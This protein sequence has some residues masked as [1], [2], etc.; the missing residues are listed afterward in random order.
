MKTINKAKRERPIKWKKITEQPQDLNEE[1]TKEEIEL[2]DVIGADNP[3]E[4]G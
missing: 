2:D 4:G 1:E 3:I